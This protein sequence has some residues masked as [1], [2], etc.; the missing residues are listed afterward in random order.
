M[1]LTRR[2]LCSLGAGLAVI[3][4]VRP[5]ASLASTDPVQDAI[6]EFTGGVVPEEGGVE[7]DAPEIA[8]NGSTVPVQVFAEG[9]S[10]ILLLANRNPNPGVATFHFGKLAAAPTAKTRVRLA[11]TQD[12][13]AVA[14]LGDGSYGLAARTVKVTIGGCGG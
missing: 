14:K 7:L 6:L 13:I 12:V 4:V 3:A 5:P 2:D 8:E 9:A 1:T 10:A 11:E